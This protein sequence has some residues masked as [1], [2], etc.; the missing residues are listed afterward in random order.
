MSVSPLNAQQLFTQLAKSFDAVRDADGLFEAVLAHHEH[1][2]K[3]KSPEGKRSWFERSPNGETFVRP[4]Y[5]VVERP[6]GDH[7]WNR[8]YRIATVSSFLEDLKASSHAPA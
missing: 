2:Q 5:R 8:P 1:V 3:D 4:P 7:G 6:E